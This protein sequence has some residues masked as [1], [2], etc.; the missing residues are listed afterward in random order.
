MASA[1]AVELLTGFDCLADASSEILILG[2]MPGL[3]SLQKQQYYAHPRNA[4]WTIMQAL[5]A[6]DA[7]ATYAER[8]AALARHKVALWDVAHQ[9]ARSGSL[10][11]DIQADTVQVNDFS[12]LFDS[13]R[14][15]SRVYFNG[16]KAA[17]LY[18]KHVLKAENQLPEHLQYTQ[19]P[20]TSAAHA[21]ITLSQKITAW[22]QI[23]S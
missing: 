5:Y 23:C 19:L 22:R 8:L 15:I 14:D 21:A 18:K 20:S 11:A 9:C 16:G 17:A 1:T 3:A 4:F 12:R 10:D 6:I 2:S 7:D 13:C